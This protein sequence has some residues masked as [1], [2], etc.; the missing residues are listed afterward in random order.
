M[1][2]N[3]PLGRALKIYLGVPRSSTHHNCDTP[4]YSQ[5]ITKTESH[6]RSYNY[7]GPRC[8]HNLHLQGKP[9]TNN[10]YQRSPKRRNDSRNWL[11]RLG[12]SSGT[13]VTLGLGLGRPRSVQRPRS[14]MQRP[15]SYLGSVSDSISLRR[16]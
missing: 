2:D 5:W 8:H 10:R 1:L 16:S 4:L 9:P 7:T 13:A 14:K 15:A 6:T 11:R 3:R 12:C